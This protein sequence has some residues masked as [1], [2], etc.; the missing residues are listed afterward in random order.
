MNTMSTVLI[1]DANKFGQ[2]MLEKMGWQQGKGL[3]PKGDGRVEHIKVSYKNDSKGMGYKESND[4]WTQHE[5]HFSALLE[6]LSGK[7]EKPDEITVKSLEKKSQSSRARVHY[8]K[9]TRGKDLSRYSEKDLANIFGKKSLKD[10]IKVEKND[11]VEE[12]EGRKENES[13]FLYNGGSMKDYF[14]SKLSKFG[15]QSEYVIGTDG[16]LKKDD[17]E[18][19]SEMRPSFGFGFKADNGHSND[20]TFVSYVSDKTTK[21][22][23]VDEILDYNIFSPRKKSKKNKQNKSLSDSGLVNAAFDPLSMPVKV[24]KHILEPINETLSEESFISAENKV[25]TTDVDVHRENSILN[26]NT[27]QFSQKKKKK[28][29]HNNVSI[30]STTIIPV[31]GDSVTNLGEENVEINLSVNSEISEMKGSKKSKKQKKVKGEFA[32][33]ECGV[34]F[35]KTTLDMDNDSSYDSKLE[36]NPFEISEMKS[37]K[38]LK[39]QKKDNS[40]PADSECGV[41]FKKAALDMDNDSSYDSKLEENPFE[42]KPKE[43]K[44]KKNKKAEFDNPTFEIYDDKSM[45]ISQGEE[46]PY[47]VKVT[48]KKKQVYEN[49]VFIDNNDDAICV[50][51]LAQREENPYE[52]KVTKKRKKVFENATLIDNQHKLS[53]SIPVNNPY[54]VKPKNKKKKKSKSTVSINDSSMASEPSIESQSSNISESTKEKK[55]HKKSLQS[56]TALTESTCKIEPEKRKQ[57][58]VSGI[59][60]PALN[61]SDNS[62]SI[63]TIEECD[64]MLNIVSTPVEVKSPAS[65]SN[66]VKKLT[67][68]KRRKSVRFSDVTQEHI[69][70]NNDDIRRM[71]SVDFTEGEDGIDNVCFD[72]QKTEFDERIETISKDIES[73]QAQIENDINENKMKSVKMEDLMVGEVGNPQGEDEL[74][75]DGNTKLKFKNANFSAHTPFY[76]LD[77]I[78]PK[79]SYKHLI[80]GDIIVKFKNS[81]LHE[82]EGY[83]MKKKKKIAA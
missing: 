30:E 4:Q 42:V 77:K 70:P 15:K 5:T 3:G 60:N 28:T 67:I 31:T 18:S 11:I 80:K 71:S 49:P 61:I 63:D 53:S 10:E 23:A 55:K 50:T 9:F 24:S 74:L 13:K 29:N 7:L 54:E 20:S 66:S 46:N 72:R 44:K 64:L 43:K 57:K 6:S 25:I 51:D 2:K 81:N 69:I 59:T 17:S 38:R 75:P 1:L 76:H 65:N 47:E 83:G 32:D 22:K 27:T 56:D 79:K 58:E 39:K 34:Q 40:E 8:H 35:E 52:V 12:E 16:V 19:E 78:G 37:L 48:R 36:E 33:S 68:L 82:I 26:T 14:K 21:R 62:E 73:C 41:Q 45:D